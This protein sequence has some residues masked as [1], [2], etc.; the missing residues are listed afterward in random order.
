M[1]RHTP[2]RGTVLRERVNPRQQRQNRVPVALVFAG[3]GWRHT[4]AA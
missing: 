2:N 4:D 3:I 1:A